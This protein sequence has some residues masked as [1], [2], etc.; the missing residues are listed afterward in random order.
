MAAIIGLCC[1]AAFLA[2]AVLAA[3]SAGVAFAGSPT[4]SR[5]SA[6]AVLTLVRSAPPTVSART[7]GRRNVSG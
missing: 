7:S 4:Q 5:S 6:K 1:V 3:L 2:I